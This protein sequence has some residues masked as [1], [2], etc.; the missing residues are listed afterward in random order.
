MQDARSLV[1]LLLLVG[2]LLG[3]TPSI[4]TE[5]TS[6]PPV[7]SYEGGVLAHVASALAA[8]I[9]ALRDLDGPPI[10]KT[11]SPVL[12]KRERKIALRYEPRTPD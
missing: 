10:E 1:V 9:N 7:T 11:G 12:C 3:A 4:A 2:R 8:R 6:L 5:D